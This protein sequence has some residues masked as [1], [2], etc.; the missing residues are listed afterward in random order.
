MNKSEV[1]GLVSLDIKKAFDLID[2]DIL[3]K[4]LSIYLKTSLSLPLFKSYLDNR[5]QCVKFFH[6][7]YSSE[8]PV[9]CGVPQGSVLGPIPFS[10]FINGL[11]LHMKNISV[12]CDMLVDDTIMT[13]VHTSRPLPLELFCAGQKIIKH[14]STVF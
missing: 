9:K 4:K 1:S 14:Q 12:D 7:S 13:M 11:P 3:L 5:M 10:L 6:G 2:H 8:S